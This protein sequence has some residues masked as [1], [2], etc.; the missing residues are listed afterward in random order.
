MLSGLGVAGD[1]FTRVEAHADEGL[2]LHQ[3]LAGKRHHKIG[4]V[5]ALCGNEKLVLI[6]A[7]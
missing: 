5:S 7:G 6:L 4:V 3:Q 2:G 1:D